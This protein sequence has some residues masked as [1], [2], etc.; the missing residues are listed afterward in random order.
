MDL[1]EL[2]MDPEVRRILTERAA[3]LASAEDQEEFE[4]GEERLTF[5]LGD[6]CY[7]LPVDFVREVRELE[8]YTPLPSVPAWIV[9]LVNV[10]GRLLTA[11][12]VRPLLENT[13]TPPQPDAFLVIVAVGDT[14][15][16]LL[17]DIVVEVRRDTADP[18]PTPASTS[19]RSMNWVRGVDQDLNLVLDMPALF[20]DPRLQIND[21]SE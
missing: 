8:A 21:E 1:Q 16:S 12:D 3:S 18:L 4:A 7:A 6:A 13:P 10:R 19:G 9:G 17:A 15:L 5:R 20:A 11:V 14:E 2:G